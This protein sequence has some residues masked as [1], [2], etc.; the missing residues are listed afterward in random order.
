M[1]IIYPKIKFSYILSSKET[2][3]EKRT[4]MIK[5]S[6]GY[7]QL[8]NGKVNYM[9]VIL[10]TG[11]ALKKSDWDSNSN[12][13][14]KE[15]RMK[16]GSDVNNHLS[17]LENGIELLIKDFVSK[18]NKL[19]EPKFVKESILELLGKKKPNIV[20]IYNLTDFIDSTIKKRTSYPVSSKLHW[21]Q[22]TA[23]Q[24][25]NLKNHILTYEKHNNVGIDKLSWQNLTE[26]IYWDF[27]NVI[28][29]CYKNENK[30][31][32]AKKSNVTD[33]LNFGYRTVTIAKIC[34]HLRAIYTEALNENI[35]VA[36]DLTKSKYKISEPN[37]KPV[38]PILTETELNKILNTY[39]DHSREFTHAKNYLIISCFTGLRIGDM[40]HLHSINS[41]T[42]VYSNEMQK[43][44]YLMDTYIRKAT[45]NGEVAR[46]LIPLPIPVLE[47]FKSNNNK[48]PQF[49]AETNIRKSISKFLKHLNFDISYQ[50]EILYYSGQKS[51]KKVKIADVFSPHDCR[52]S[53]ITNLISFGVSREKIEYITHPKFSKKN[54]IDLYDKSTL[55]EKAIR[56]AEDIANNKKDS[57]LY[58]F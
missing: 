1:Y 11:I 39:T 52:S 48:F 51:I 53:Y 47:I 41:P 37:K 15:Y 12:R 40:V 7:S 34:K 33:E 58:C 8:V 30:K 27:F 42:E 36:F 10:S 2:T 3:E 50:S 43:S 28:D 14:T 22:K 4:L 44:I 55:E 17:R 20:V 16:H 23:N 35:S 49:P 19:P 45:S 18:N 31:K 26:D 5:V 24:Y 56:L 13:V 57:K 32:L 54:M 46:V 21:T 6:Y 9:P 29:S 38:N 25:I